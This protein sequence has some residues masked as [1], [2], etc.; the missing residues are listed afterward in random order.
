MRFDDQPGAH[1]AILRGRAEQV[2]QHRPGAQR[3]G[4][5][6]APVDRVQ[7]LAADFHR[8]GLKLL[9]IET[10]SA[11]LAA[12]AIVVAHQVQ[13]GLVAAGRRVR[14]GNEL[15][16]EKTALRQRN[17]LDQRLAIARPGNH[18]LQGDVFD[19]AH[20]VVL[21]DHAEIDRLAGTVDTAVGEQVGVQR[22]RLVG[23]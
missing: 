1:L 8:V 23:R 17:P 21:D 6:P 3:L 22:I 7:Q 14:A 13:A 20:V 5:I 18:Q 15:V 11:D 19:V 16:V 2:G 10:Q 9:D 12:A 4:R